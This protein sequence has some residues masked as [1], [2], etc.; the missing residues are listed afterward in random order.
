[1]EGVEN[2]YEGTM[3][4]VGM[5]RGKVNKNKE[6][7]ILTSLTE[8]EDEIENER[9]CEVGRNS[10]NKPIVRIRIRFRIR[11]IMGYP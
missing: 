8:I 7:W 6:N 9:K 2:L 3:E 10:G 1:M 11:R 5:K 4:S